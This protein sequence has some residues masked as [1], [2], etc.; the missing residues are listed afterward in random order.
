[1]SPSLSVL[2]RALDRVA[3]HPWPLLVAVTVVAAVVEGLTGPTFTS[4]RYIRIGATVLF[5]PQGLHFYALHPEVQMGPLTL[6]VAA[7]FVLLLHGVVGRGAAMVALLLLGLLALREV[8]AR[9][10]PVD[11]A[12]R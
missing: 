7:P 1:Q 2:S 9:V 10:D 4:W 6:V 5:S 8:Q 11:R 12:G 3:D